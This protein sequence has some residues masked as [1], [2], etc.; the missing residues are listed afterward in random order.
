M[1][2]PQRQRHPL[3]L[4]CLL[5]IYVT[6]LYINIRHHY[7]IAYR[8]LRKNLYNNIP[9]SG[10]SLIQAASGCRGS[11]LSSADVRPTNVAAEA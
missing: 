8:F 4:C 1:S 9:Y 6:T 7:Y 2:L 11:Q 10:I 3:S 5:I